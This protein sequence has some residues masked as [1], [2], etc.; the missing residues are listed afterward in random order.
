MI[1]GY[2]RY[3]VFQGRTIFNADDYGWGSGS[4]YGNALGSN[5]TVSGSGFGSGF[6]TTGTTRSG[7]FTYYLDCI[8]ATADRVGMPITHKKTLPGGSQPSRIQLR[9]KYSANTVQG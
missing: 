6:S 1:G 7:A 9:K 2:G 8:D 4:F 3:I 5:G